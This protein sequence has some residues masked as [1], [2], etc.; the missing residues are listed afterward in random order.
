VAHGG[1]LRTGLAITAVLT[2]LLGLIP[3]PFLASVQ[4]AADAVGTAIR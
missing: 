4:S 1:L 3:Q 2:I